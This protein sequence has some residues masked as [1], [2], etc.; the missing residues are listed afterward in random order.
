MIMFC[1]L[2]VTPLC[3][4]V[5]VSSHNVSS[6]NANL[7]HCRDARDAR[8]LL[9][10]PELPLAK[11]IIF[12]PELFGSATA[13]HLLFDTPIEMSL[14][15]PYLAFDCRYRIQFETSAGATD[16]DECSTEAAAIQF[17]ASQPTIANEVAD[18]RVDQSDWSQERP[19][20]AVQ[21]H[22][23][24]NNS[25]AT[26]EWDH[27]PNAAYP[28]ALADQRYGAYYIA[29]RSC[30]RVKQSETFE[31]SSVKYTANIALKDLLQ[32]GALAVTSLANDT[33]RVASYSMH[34]SLATPAAPH[35]GTNR[36]HTHIYTDKYD[37]MARVT[38]VNGFSL[39]SPTTVLSATIGSL[40]I[41]DADEDR[42][43]FVLVVRTRSALHHENLSVH[44]S[45]TTD[46]VA[47]RHVDQP[48]KLND[49][50]YIHYLYFASN[51]TATVVSEKLTI[52][53]RPH[54]HSHHSDISSITITLFVT[55]PRALE[56]GRDERPPLTNQATL[57]A[58]HG[59]V[60][61]ESQV[62]DGLRVCVINNVVMPPDMAEIVGV[63]LVEA[64]LCVMSS[65]D[66]SRNKLRCADQRHAIVLLKDGVLNEQHNVS[67]VSP[68]RLGPA[69]VELCF[70]TSLEI[71]DNDQLTLEAPTQRYESRIELVPLTT[72][73]GKPSLFDSLSRVGERELHSHNAA[74]RNDSTQLE[75]YSPFHV[76]RAVRKIGHAN[77]EFHVSAFSFDIA[78]LIGTTHHISTFSSNLIVVLVFV[79]FF[80]VVGAY[81]L[82]SSFDITRFL[83]QPTFTEYYKK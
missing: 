49:G 66:N 80:C 41:V 10:L 46:G 29:P 70:V 7:H 62:V 11:Q 44:S 17:A 31:C 3:L 32:C 16:S 56:N 65:G 1:A 37:N 63:R 35:Y 50:T 25:T 54:T 15:L 77:A 21:Q 47:L 12:T 38:L 2:L 68:G 72:I 39:G 8:N 13:T 43:E 22:N 6:A 73:L 42:F 74:L 4:A 30:W 20:A 64:W 14:E 45:R 19:S 33:I 24:N 78:P 83:R 59:L 61:Q 23:N 69:S 5:H 34:V 67:I 52:D 51:T 71:T 27:A 75:A 26:H 58:G 81:M 53:V 40:G 57:F 82:L 18:N 60:Q 28:F 76:Q 36:I 9:I 79:M 55:N 48:F